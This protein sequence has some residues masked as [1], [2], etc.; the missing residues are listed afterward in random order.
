MGDGAMLFFDGGADANDRRA[1]GPAKN[2]IKPSEG[3]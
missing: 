3:S 1:V 2:R